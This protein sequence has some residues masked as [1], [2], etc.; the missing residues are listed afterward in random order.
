MIDPPQALPPD[1]DE[2]EDEEPIGTS[3]TRRWILGAVAAALVTVLIAGPVWQAIDRAQPTVAPNGLEVCVYDYCSV[4]AE[5]RVAGYGP[6]MARLASVE[7][8]ESQ[9]QAVANDLASMI[10]EAAVAVEVIDRLPGDLAGS[11]EPAER[12]IFV[13]R[14][15]RAWTLVHEVAHVAATGHGPAFI[16]VLTDLLVEIERGSR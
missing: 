4:Q 9:A 10:G 13:E 3:S 14:P 6:Q 1:S 7:I 16:A 2:F 12:L 5:M 11:Y 8:D 15:I